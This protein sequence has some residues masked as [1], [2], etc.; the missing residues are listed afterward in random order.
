MTKVCT[1]SFLWSVLCNLFWSPLIIIFL[2]TDGAETSPSKGRLLQA[3]EMLQEAQTSTPPLV[4][5][6]PSDLPPI[7]R[8]GS[9]SKSAPSGIASLDC[10][11]WKID[12]LLHCYG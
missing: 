11:Q 6:I 3:Y 1:K 5:N 7:S 9:Q 4:F 8:I 10:R 2:F 12:S